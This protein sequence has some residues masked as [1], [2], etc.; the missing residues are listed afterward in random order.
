VHQLVQEVQRDSIAEQ[1]GG[2]RR[3]AAALVLGGDPSARWT[4]AEWRRLADRLQTR[5]IDVVATPELVD[6]VVQQLGTGPLTPPMPV[7]LLGA[8]GMGKTTVARMVATDDRVRGRF[9]GGSMM[10][11]LGRYQAAGA[12]VAIVHD[13]LLQLTGEDHRPADA[14]AARTVLQKALAGMRQS[15]LLILD[16]VW[17]R[18]HLALFLGDHHHGILVT[19]RN[20]AMTS[21][22]SIL[23]VQPHM[24]RRH[25]I[26]LLRRG[27]PQLAAPLADEMAM[28][29]GD[30]ALALALVNSHLRAVHARNPADLP[31]RAREII[32]QVNSYLNARDHHQPIMLGLV[33]VTLQGALAPL[34]E[35]DRRRVLEL[36]VFPEDEQI[37]LAQIAQL[38]AMTADQTCSLVH[39]AHDLGLLEFDQRSETVLLHDTVREAFIAARTVSDS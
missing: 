27:L 37:P 5:L 36:A 2:V 4:E 3:R 19:T 28:T 35:T 14:G 38:W 8:G 26:D 7:A 18:E 9:P 6:E 20:F 31:S 12:E 23:E 10:F 34:P 24:W 30:W 11:L 32:T 33:D 29:C 15:T 16:D 17:R 21:Q 22:Q 39:D 13:A 25:S 1:S